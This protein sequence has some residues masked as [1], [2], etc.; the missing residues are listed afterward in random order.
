[1]NA[2]VY[3]WP[4][5]R[6]YALDVTCDVCGGFAWTCPCAVADNDSTGQSDDGDGA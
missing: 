5:P 1:M 3:F 2:P 4:T 6:A